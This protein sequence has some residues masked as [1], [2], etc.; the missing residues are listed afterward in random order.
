MFDSR[1]HGC[2]S[3]W[4]PVRRI[5]RR[6]GICRGERNIRR[7]GRREEKR[8]EEKRGED[9]GEEGKR[10]RE[11]ERGVG[12]GEGEQETIDEGT[13]GKVEDGRE[14]ERSGG[15]NESKL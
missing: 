14:I 10:Y 6:E 4:I 5:L 2:K 9:C 13:G 3:Y 11:R 1:F 8:R 7:E 15:N 12:E